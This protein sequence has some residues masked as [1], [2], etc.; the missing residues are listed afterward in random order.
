MFMSLLE[1]IKTK[2][3]NDYIPIVID[4]TLYLINSLINK[5]QY[6]SILEIGTAYGYSAYCF[7]LNKSI[8]NITS[9]EKNKTNYEMASSFLS[10]QRKIQ[11]INA[12]A[13][14]HNV[15]ETFDLIFIDGP[16]SHQQELVNKYY[17]CLN[18][19]G[20][21]IIDNIYLKKFINITNLTKNQKNLIN[22]VN[23]FKS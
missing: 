21:M 20:V 22:K 6:K 3:L 12:N 14:E 4:K 15:D 10:N 2:C 19:D 7:S 16:K 13:F 18:K 17:Q 9:I 5:N 23:E 8:H 1:T 11:L